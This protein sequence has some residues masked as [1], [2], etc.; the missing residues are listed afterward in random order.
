[1]LT[2]ITATELRPGVVV[3]NR[4]GYPVQ[5]TEVENHENRPYVEFW[6][7]GIGFRVPNGEIFTLA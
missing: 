5:I 7:R 1:M 2:T 4:T 6:S 3:L